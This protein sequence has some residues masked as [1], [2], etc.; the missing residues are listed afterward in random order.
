MRTS[1]S[2]GRRE[3]VDGRQPL[4]AAE[5]TASRLIFV[6]V[7]DVN[8]RLVRMKAGRRDAVRE[9]HRA[10]VLGVLRDHGSA[11]RADLMRATGLSRPTIS[12]IVGELLESGAVREVGKY[13]AGAS[14]GRPSQLLALT[15]PGGLALSV[16]VGHS[17]L[18][19]IVA[20]A[21]GHVVQERS[22]AFGQRLPVERTLTEAARLIAEVTAAAKVDTNGLIGATVGL[23]SPVDLSGRPLARRFAHLDPL[24]LLGLSAYTDQVRIVNDADLGAAGEAAFGA[25]ARF[26]NFVF[27]KISQ[28]VGAGLILGGRLYRGR[29]YAGN[30]G[31]V[32]V[33]SEGEVC[34]CGNRG[35]LETVASSGALIRALQPAH[36][37]AIGFSDL[38]RLA[39]A[40]DPGTQALLM[41]AGRSVG[42]VLSTLVATLNPDAIV[43]G[44]TL[45]AL[46]GPLLRGIEDS[47]HR[48]CQPSIVGDLVVTRAGCG[49]HAEVLGGIAM[50]FGLVEDSGS[51]DGPANHQR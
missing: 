9:L 31:H 19:A 20:D 11:S 49:D 33:V 50:A 43:V 23:A 37:A 29:G 32:R 21:S 40:G 1:P 13:T 46:G 3:E 10:H 41:D 39:D 35:C 47:L 14:K 22:V 17:H 4:V 34:I 12:S 2:L 18:R 30:I 38:V 51:P 27:V 42:K 28:G 5:G 26:G 7:S 8:G 15:P 44:G 24:D 25:G 48:Y 16:D 6:K 45:G 36:D